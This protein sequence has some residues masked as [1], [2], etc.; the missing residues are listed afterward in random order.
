[1]LRQWQFHNNQN[2][3]HRQ[4]RLG[5]IARILGKSNRSAGIWEAIGFPCASSD[6]VLM[7]PS[8]AM[9]HYTQDILDTRLGLQTRPHWLD[10]IV[11]V[12]TLVNQYIYD[13]EINQLHRLIE[14]EGY[15]QDYKV[16]LNSLSSP[17][18]SHLRGMPAFTPLDP[19]FF[20]LLPDP[21][22]GWKEHSF[23]T[24]GF[25]EKFHPRHREMVCYTHGDRKCVCKSCFTREFTTLPVITTNS[26]NG[27][28]TTMHAAPGNTRGRSSPWYMKA[29]YC[30]KCLD[31]HLDHV[32]NMQT[33]DFLRMMAERLEQNRG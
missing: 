3:A 33:L 29:K 17:L 9:L 22:C 28:A 14:E 13:C 7:K 11:F 20:V 30:S 25:C 26:R 19:R 27:I 4:D 10:D 15:Q 24:C 8:K 31:R 6:E 5:V 18:T 1:M 16:Y 2:F 23:V 32:E 12:R 21:D